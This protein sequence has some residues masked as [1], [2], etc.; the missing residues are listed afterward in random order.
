VACV[1]PCST[2]GML[3]GL[4]FLVYWNKHYLN[5]LTNSNLPTETSKNKSSLTP[6]EL[7]KIQS[8][9]NLRLLSLQPSLD[10]IILS[11]TLFNDL[12]AFCSYLFTDIKDMKSLAF[13]KLALII[14]LYLCE[15]DPI[16][17][18]FHQK[19]NDSIRFYSGK[20]GGVTLAKFPPCSIIVE[21]LIHFMRNNL[22]KRKI[23]VDLYCKCLMTIE[24]ILVFEKNHSISLSPSYKWAELWSTLFWILRTISEQSLLMEKPEIFAIISEIGAVFDMFVSYG[25]TLLTENECYELYYEILR[26]RDIISNVQYFVSQ[27]SQQQQQQSYGQALSQHWPTLNSIIEHFGKEINHWHEENPECSINYNDVSY[28]SFGKIFDITMETNPLLQ[29]RNIIRHHSTAL[30]LP[31]TANLDYYEKYAENPKETS[32][33]RQLFRI[34]VSDFRT[35]FEII[36]VPL[37][38]ADSMRMPYL[39]STSDLS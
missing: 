39:S 19:S 8:G 21:L 35:A 34:L 38:I 4:Y 18:A 14:L 5:F 7:Q 3:L 2:G 9:N 11:T 23:Q 31:A 37:S 12:F 25:D 17:F 1:S 29:V 26:N 22:N 36:A 28:L 20:K 27:H 24:R 13:S 16:M 30:H 10:C 32:F 33:F 6:L 15:N